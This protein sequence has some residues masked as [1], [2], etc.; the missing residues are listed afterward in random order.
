MTGNGVTAG[1]PGT[2]AAANSDLDGDV[3][4]NQPL[5]LTFSPGLTSLSEAKR[6]KKK[7]N[8]YKVSGVN[9]LNRNSV[10][11]KTALERLQRRR[12]NHNFVERRR[13]DNINHTITTLASLIPSCAEEG[14]K[15]NK[16]SILH[17]AVEYI[18]DL[19]YINDALVTENQS[20]GGS[21]HVTLPE[22]VRRSPLPSGLSTA[23]HSQ[24]EY[25]DDDDMLPSS[26]AAS[27][28]SATAQP[29]A[30]GRKRSSSRS[31]PASRAMAEKRQTL[32][33]P[34]TR[35]TASSAASPVAFQ[36]TS[37]LMPPLPAMSTPHSPQ[38]PMLASGG[39]TGTHTP[40]PPI[41]TLSTP[42]SSISRLPP[43]SMPSSPRLCPRQQVRSSTDTTHQHIPSFSSHPFFNDVSSVRHHLQLREQQSPESRGLPP[44]ASRNS[45][46]A[47]SLQS[48][49]LMRPARGSAFGGS[50]L[51]PISVT[52]HGES[53][54]P[55]SRHMSPGY[56]QQ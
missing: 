55:L 50:D 2:C 56:P 10:D 26:T 6:Q 15:V 43:Q 25:D 12:E 4:S 35:E 36:P 41:G 38:P 17:M 46:C 40:L 31:S 53:Q 7:S 48:T 51:P 3:Q 13:R 20:L 21:G 49:P 39:S 23:Q 9:I 42:M 30:T 18:R 33:P 22:R 1:S 24:D 8:V 52:M 34:R 5:F 16:G 45:Y 27:S 54:P 44:M 29:F 11:S 28:P 14:A 32:A 47:Q 19:R 37:T